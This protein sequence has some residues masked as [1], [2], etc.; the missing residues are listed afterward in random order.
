MI[1]Y[2]NIAQMNRSLD[3]ALELE[4]KGEEAEQRAELFRAFIKACS[5]V[6]VSELERLRAANVHPAHELKRLTQKASKYGARSP[7]DFVKATLH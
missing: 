6:S 3:R 1:Y 2:Q 7:Y 4:N 5:L